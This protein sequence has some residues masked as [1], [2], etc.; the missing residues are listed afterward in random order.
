MKQCPKCVWRT[1]CYTEPMC[2]KARQILHDTD[3]ANE[4][5]KKYKNLDCLY[6]IDRRQTET[7]YTTIKEGEIDHFQFLI[8]QY[9]SLGYSK[10]LSVMLKNIQRALGVI[11]E[12]HKE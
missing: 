9:Q 4:I 1:Y 2:D 5:Y 8:K 12:C 11:V 7:T 10:R 6:F 3:I